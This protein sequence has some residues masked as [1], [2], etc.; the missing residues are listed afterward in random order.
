M[1]TRFL[2]LLAA[3]AISS[4][5]AQPPTLGINR[6]LQLQLFGHIN[7]YYQLESSTNLTHWNA[8][9]TNFPVASVPQVT[10]LSPGTSPVFFRARALVFGTNASVWTTC[11]E[12]DNVNIPLRGDVRGFTIKALHPA[13]TV[14]QSDCTPNFN[15]C[16]NSGGTDYPFTPLSAK[17]FDNGTDYFIVTRQAAFWRPYGMDVAINGAVLYTNIHYVQ[18]GRKVPGVSSWP[19]FLALYCDGN[20]RLIPFPPA[21]LPDVCFGTS[22]IVGP[23]LPAT[24]PM[25]EIAALDYRPVSRTLLLTYRTGGTAI[26]D[27]N[28][29]SRT[30]ATVGVTVNYPTDQPFCTIR[31]M[32]V[33]DGNCDM[34]TVSFLGLDNV[35]EMLPVMAFT[36]GLSSTWSFTRSQYSAHNNSAPDLYI[37]TR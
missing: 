9:G 25:A 19:I 24:R 15:S 26:L 4:T 27:V 21:N 2:A 7:N 23:A 36:T 17:P 30:N 10:T 12:D 35:V 37:L 5:M 14:T 34:D 29:L 33:T 3:S 32:Y 16:T 31:S 8:Y 28:T 20:L 22:V 6:G 18:L 13:Y 1:K 11:A